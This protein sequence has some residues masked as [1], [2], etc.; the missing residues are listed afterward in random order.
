MP[1]TS[2]LRSLS[3]RT[4]QYIDDRLALANVL[5]AVDPLSEGYR[6]A[7]ILVALLTRLDYTLALG[8]CSFVPSTCVKFLG[9]LIDSQRQAYILPECKRLKFA[10]LKESILNSKRLV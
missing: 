8:K 6:V 5:E 9:F 1:V 4:V 10:A 3:L 7:Y 2:Y